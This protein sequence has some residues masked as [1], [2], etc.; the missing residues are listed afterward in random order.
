VQGSLALGGAVLAESSLSFL[1]I[2]IEPP[3]ATWGVI[4]ADRFSIIRQNPW[5]S[6]TPGVAI[7]LFVLS[8]NLMGDCLRDVLDPRL[9]GAR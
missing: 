9:R 1:G 8:V 4:I 3:T 2:G 7:V 5:V 6:I